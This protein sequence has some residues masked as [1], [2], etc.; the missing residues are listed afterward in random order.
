MEGFFTESFSSRRC[1]PSPSAILGAY[2]SSHLPERLLRVVFGVLLLYLAVAMLR[3]KK[4]DCEMEKGKIEYRN[5]PP[6]S[7][8]F[9]DWFRDCWVSVGVS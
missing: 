3:S 2:L 6:W 1:F 4:G 7:G 5:V 8:W 9:R